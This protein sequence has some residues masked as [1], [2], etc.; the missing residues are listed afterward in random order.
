MAF[1]FFKFWKGINLRPESS[2]STAAQGDVQVLSSDGKARFHNGTSS[3]PVV[4]ESHAS[5]GANRLK[6]KDLE[7][8]T[9]AVVDATD[10]TKKIKFDA[11]GTTGTSTTILGSQTADRTI[12]LPDATDTL[13]GKAT[14]DVLTNKTITGNTAVNLVSGSGTFTLNTSGTVTA[15]NATDTLVGKA[16]TDSLTNKTISGSTNSISIYDAN[17]TIQ[18]DGDATKQ[19]KFQASGITTG[20]TRTLTIPDASTT[21]VGTDATQTLTNKTLS[22][23]TA[24]NLISGAGTLTLNTSGT[25]TVPNATDTLVGKNT[26][27]T[28]TNKTLTTP[29]I[30]QISNTGTLTLPTS[31]DTLVARATTDTLSNKTMGD[32]LT[33]TQIATPSN[34][35]TGFNKLYAKSDGNFYNLNSAGT[36]TLLG[37]SSTAVDQPFNLSNLGLST[38]VAA[39]AMTVALKQRDG[40]S[41]P[42]SGSGAVGVTFRSSTLTTGGYTTVSVTA[43]TS[44]TIPSG[45]TLGSTNNN[46]A[47]FYVYAI[48]NA[49]TVELAVS[50]KIWDEALLWNTTA[51][52]SGSTSALLLY[53]TTARTNVSVRLIGKVG[54][55]EVTAG[56]WAS[57]ATSVA[58]GFFSEPAN[59]FIGT[60]QTFNSN[61]TY[62]VPVGVSLISVT[63][64][65]GG[66][67]GG[68]GSA[69]AYQAGLQYFGNEGGS[70]TDT[71]FGSLLTAK[72]GRYAQ[73]GIPTGSISSGPTAITGQGGFAS[74]G[75]GGAGGAGNNGANASAG[76]AAAANTGAGGGGG[77]G[78]TD[79]VTG[80]LA[81][82]GHGGIGA[83]VITQIFSVT[84]GQQ[85]SVT[86]GTG[87]SGGSSVT[88]I[89]FN[90][91][92]GGAGGSGV[93]KVITIG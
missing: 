83:P 54:Y 60:A 39:N 53:S 6:S 89:G 74:Y 75:A 19:A 29:V 90:S 33:F 71:T 84:P 91:G 58:V 5:Q 2:D 36:E 87:G 7:D 8:S 67:G 25:I 46:A 70:G 35:S 28:L 77:G 41:N 23:N 86:I 42:A 61:G 13:V 48:N 17:F 76:S 63:A 32:A 37:S 16:T 51:I 81:Y 66:G 9:T 12:T 40:T 45:A 85:I 38:S 22:G 26:T 21:L 20:T 1:N 62:V 55:S 69:S 79:N 73:G 43:S 27:D 44:I 93:V 30:S 24:T 18:D 59:D 78:V 82:G 4:T 10:T 47:Y 50:S 88:N 15:P 11:A 14:T 3:S 52:S 68:S 57:N 34:P 72:G 56:T 65:G 31:T 80:S 92:A 49:G 64:C